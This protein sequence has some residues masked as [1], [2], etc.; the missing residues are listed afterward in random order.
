MSEN[1]EDKPEIAFF[2]GF[3]PDGGA[4]FSIEGRVENLG[5]G[6]WNLSPVLIARF[7]WKRYGEKRLVWNADDPLSVA[8]AEAGIEDACAAVPFF[9][10][11]GRVLGGPPITKEATH[12]YFCGY[13]RALEEIAKKNGSA[14]RAPVRMPASEE[15][16][17]P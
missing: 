3:A 7:A 13:A 9:P 14:V 15:T 16:T 10:R 1:A 8:A 6:Q 2:G 11:A 5:G 12:A 17:T 4:L